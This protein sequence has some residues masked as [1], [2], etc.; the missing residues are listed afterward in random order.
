[1]EIV[2]IRVRHSIVE[3]MQ[4][5]GPVVIIARAEHIRLNVSVNVAKAVKFLNCLAGVTEAF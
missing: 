1:M 3:A 4:D 2:G 5:Q